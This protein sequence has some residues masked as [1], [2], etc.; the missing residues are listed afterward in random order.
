MNSS[1]NGRPRLSY[2]RRDDQLIIK[3]FLA[4]K[5]VERLGGN[6]CWKRLAKESKVSPI[7]R[8]SIHLQGSLRISGY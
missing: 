3:Y 4:T 7:S 6:E 1:S 5:D 2:T 8:I